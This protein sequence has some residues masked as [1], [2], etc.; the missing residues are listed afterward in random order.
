MKPQIRLRIIV[1]DPPPNVAFAIQLGRSEM[2]PAVHA[3]KERLTFEFQLTVAD[4]NADPPRLTGDCAQ[5]PAQKRF[6]YVNSGSMA[7]QDASCWTRRA[8]IPLYG[9]TCATLQKVLEEK[10]SVLETVVSGRSKDG[11][12]ACATVPLLTPWTSKISNEPIN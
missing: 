2:L 4:A 8:K 3:S 10:H 1:V 7:G 11:G 6:V 5:G 9:I 12:P